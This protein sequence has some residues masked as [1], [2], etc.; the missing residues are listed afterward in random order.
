MK[1][2]G[3]AQ[4]H[5]EC[6][7]EQ[8]VVT[9]VLSGVWTTIDD[10]ELTAHAAECQVCGEVAA[11][12]ALLRT[13]AEQARREVH[14]PAAGQVWWRAAVRAR[15]ERTHASTQPMTLMHGVTAAI[16]IGLLLAILGMAWPTIAGAVGGVKTLAA[17]M[18]AN[19]DIIAAVVSAFRQSLTLALVVTAG[20]IIT[21]VAIYFALSD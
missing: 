17:E 7:R 11:I 2:F 12:S 10:E 3:Y 13:D 21:P 5:D 19:G 16:A 1:R 20:L 18:P 9:A 4:E 14:V 8:E 15:L 6:R